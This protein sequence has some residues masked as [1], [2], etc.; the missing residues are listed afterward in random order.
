M[1]DSERNL[2]ELLGA[3]VPKSQFRLLGTDQ[4][5]AGKDLVVQDHCIN[6]RTIVEHIFGVYV[7]VA[8]LYALVRGFPLHFK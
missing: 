3:K 6:V 4:D 7:H 8:E 1:L 5:V 2:E